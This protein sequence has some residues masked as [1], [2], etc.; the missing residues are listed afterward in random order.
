MKICPFI[1]HLLGDE[2]HNT[3]SLGE[4]T[5]D[6]DRTGASEDVVIL[7]YNDDFDF[8]Q[9]EL[10]LKNRSNRQL[11]QFFSTFMRNNK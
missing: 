9:V 6:G 1:S 10:K 2:N 3:L 8:L 11:K 7:G 4:K 5:T